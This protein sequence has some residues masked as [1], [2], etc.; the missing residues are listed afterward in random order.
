MTNIIKTTNKDID[1]LAQ[2][3]SELWTENESEEIVGGILIL[4]SAYFSEHK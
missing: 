3:V 2:M 1:D 4:S